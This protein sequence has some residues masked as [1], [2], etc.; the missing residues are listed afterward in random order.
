MED[1]SLKTKQER[2]DE[3][4][5]QSFEGENF[6]ISTNF[7]RCC[8]VPDIDVIVICTLLEEFTCLFE[9]I[10]SHKTENQNCTHALVNF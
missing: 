1:F 9:T 10:I 3:K 2:S 4:H 8:S 6:S 5:Y 7:N